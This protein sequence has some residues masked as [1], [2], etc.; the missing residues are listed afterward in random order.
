M[1]ADPKSD[2]N[3]ARSYR[4]NHD[5]SQ[6]T[7]LLSRTPTAL[8]ALLRDL[9][10][11]LTHSNEGP[12]TWSAFDVVGHLI[13]AEH[14]DW[15][16]RATMILKHGESETFRPFNRE[17]QT[18]KSQGKSL[19]QLLDEFAAAR[20]ESLAQLRAMNL[21]PHD[22]D[23]RGR[24]PNFGPVTLGQLLATW[25]AHDLT[26]L[27]QLTRL[28]ACQYREAVG[29]WSVFLGVLQCHGHSSDA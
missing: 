18:E 26:H 23:R 2:S 12:N 11:S 13:H 14:T 15:I 28:M 4:M 9:P 20:A 27:H 24:H 17:G 29:P 25:A 7:A 1:N 3:Y 22:L 19:P 8:N 10:E 6:T 16:P 5:L 21:Q